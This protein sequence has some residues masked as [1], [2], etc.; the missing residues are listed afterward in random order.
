VNAYEQKQAARKARLE[1]AAATAGATATAAFNRAAAIS[2]RF[3]M[4]QPILVGHHS[5]GR[6]RR[7][8]ARMHDAMTRGVA[9]KRDADALARRAAGVGTAGVSSDD[10]DAIAKL[11]AELAK[12]RSAQ[13]ACKAINAA[14][15]KHAKAGPEAQR[16]A[17]LALG[18][19][20]RVA[21]SA[22]TPDDFGRLGVADY[23]I[24]NRGANI[25][26]IEKR[27]AELRAKAAAPVREPITGPGYAIVEDRDAN[28]VQI[29]F[30]ARPPAAT[31]AALKARGFRWAPSENAWQRQASNGA[32]HAAQAVAASLD[33]GEIVP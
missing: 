29:R 8:Q 18:I 22:M 26:R 24:K 11:E 31:V 15:R 25:R 5:E 19:S 23:A 3:V 17:L 16:A 2:E 21:A 13:D 32:W 9:A 6:A 28:R 30:D 1:R 20:E 14:I 4:G 27:I 10:P 33:A 7:D 12:E